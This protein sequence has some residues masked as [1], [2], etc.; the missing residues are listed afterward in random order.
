MW[1]FTPKVSQ[2]FRPLYTYHSVGFN[3]LSYHQSEKGNNSGDLSLNTA[4]YASQMATRII[5]QYEGVQKIIQCW[6][7]FSNSTLRVVKMI[8]NQKVRE[9]EKQKIRISKSRRLFIQ[10]TQCRGSK[11]PFPLFRFLVLTL[12]TQTRQV[13]QVGSV[14]NLYLYLN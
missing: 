6:N 8:L 3:Y 13:L 12:A 14:K 10:S 4:Y 2:C 11:N 9:N 5:Q 1:L 7:L